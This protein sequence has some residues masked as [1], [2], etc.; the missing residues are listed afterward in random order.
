ME[1]QVKRL[2]GTAKTPT[3]GSFHAA[4]LDLYADESLSIAPR[5]RRMVRTGV[6]L[7]IP[8]HHV[9]LIWPRSGLALK[10]GLATMAGVIDSDYRGEIQVLLRNTDKYELVHIEKGDRVA[11]LIV[12]PVTMLTVVEVKE[13][14]A[15]HRGHGGFGST[16]A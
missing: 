9:G 13:L 4:G 1:I 15:T 5:E 16:G 7:S 8:P 14:D 2:S 3:R 6:S 12:Q 10:K 11:Q